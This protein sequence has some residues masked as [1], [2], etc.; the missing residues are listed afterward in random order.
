MHR[1]EA[2]TCKRAGHIAAACHVLGQSIQ[3]V[4]PACHLARGSGVAIVSRTAIDRSCL[5]RCTKTW[6]TISLHVQLHAA[7]V[8]LWALR[9]MQ[10]LQRPYVLLSLIQ[11]SV[12]AFWVG[13]FCRQ[14]PALA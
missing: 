8:R 4:H 14:R 3:R 2:W 6:C 1:S 12:C 13:K 9:L 10:Q 11:A 7:R 5:A